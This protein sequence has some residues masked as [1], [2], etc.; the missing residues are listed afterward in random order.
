MDDFGTALV[1]AIGLVL[2]IEGLVYAL[3]PEGAKR[4]AAYASALPGGTLRRGGLI[5]AALGVGVV[6]LVRG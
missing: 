1:T 2:V 5:A 6:W 4:L 3:F